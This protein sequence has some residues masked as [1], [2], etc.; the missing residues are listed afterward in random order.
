MARQKN[1][2]IAGLSISG[3]IALI[4]LIALFFGFILPWI[5]VEE[6]HVY[7]RSADIGNIWVE[8]G[9]ETPYSHY[10]SGSTSDVGSI[11][12]LNITITDRENNDTLYF[13]VGVKKVGDHV[14]KWRDVQEGEYDIIVQYKYHDDVMDEE[15]YP[16][17]YPY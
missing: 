17:T 6:I 3:L 11:Y 8:K 13:K 4:A 5:S 12:Y 16:F 10:F 1:K 2:V 7:A 15:I 14:V 9:R